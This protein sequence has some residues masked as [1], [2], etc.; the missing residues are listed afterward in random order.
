MTNTRRGDLRPLRPALLALALLAPP[1]LLATF[2]AAAQPASSQ[3]AANLS[4]DLEAIRREADVPA[5]AA[6]ALREG[7][8]VAA[9]AAGV[10]ARGSPERVALDDRF[11]LGS[12]GKAMT[13]TMLATLVEEGKLKWTTTVAE[14]LPEIAG[15]IRE[16]FREATLEQLLTH[17]SGLPDD[18]QGGPLLLRIRA[19]QGTLPEQRR[20][21]ARLILR[22]KPAA[23]RGA[24]TV[25]SNGG[26]V[27]AAAMAEQVTGK[28]F[29]ELMSQRVFR[30]LKLGTAGFGPPG[31]NVAIDQPRGHGGLMGDGANE[32]E[33]ALA[34]NPASLRPA[35]GIHMSLGDWARFAALHL[36][37]G[38]RDAALLKRETIEKL[39]APPEGARYAMGWSVTKQPDGG[40]KLGHAG[41]NSMWFAVI[42]LYPERDVVLLVACNAGS[43][44]AQSACTR[45]METLRKSALAPPP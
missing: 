29:E 10:R 42:E 41:S 14:A 24:E 20:E 39:H 45:A 5:L 31:S 36:S 9:G 7:Q 12:C 38:R 40:I 17:R 44:A 22:Q 30:P 28:P 26:Y 4:D 13:A 35:G 1:S 11:H 15:D 18:R 32:P 3:P 34:D 33:S 16:Q 23:P 19:L 6:A 43:P 25:Y 21:A 37:P 2:T 27:V 8:V